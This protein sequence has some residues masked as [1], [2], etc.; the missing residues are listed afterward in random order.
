[1][2]LLTP[3][4][5][6]LFWMVIVFLAVFLVLARWG[7]PVITK[8]IEERRAY[9]T[10]SMRSADE[11]NRR[12]AEIKDEAEALLSEASSQR[13]K[14]VAN[15]SREADEIIRRAREK[16][17]EE[18]RKE[19]EKALEQIAAERDNAMAQISDHAASLSIAIAEKVLRGEL[20]DPAAAKEYV[21]KM[22]GEL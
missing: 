4:F 1:M 14:T 8:M 16:A 12:L 21:D 6:L 22:K 3:D 10:E 5:G 9:I 19:L 20:R 13:L 2:N 7:F 15:A 11:A 18:G 17:A